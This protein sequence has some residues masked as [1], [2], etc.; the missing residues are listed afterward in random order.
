MSTP[1]EYFGGVEAEDG[2]KLCTW[3]GELYLELHNGTYTTHAKV[4]FFLRQ[5]W[6]TK[7]NRIKYKTQRK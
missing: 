5:N 6:K 7:A 4:G 3:A 2:K 1:D